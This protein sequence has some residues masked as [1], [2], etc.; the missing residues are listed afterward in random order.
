MLP[1][2]FDNSTFNDFF[3]WNFLPVET[4]KA[5][6]NFYTVKKSEDGYKYVFK[7]N[8]DSDSYHTT[9]SEKERI[10]EVSVVGKVRKGSYTMSHSNLET[11]EFEDDANLE[12]LTEKVTEEGLVI[13]VKRNAKKK[14]EVPEEDENPKWTVRDRLINKLKGEKTNDKELIRKLYAE[15]DDRDKE[16]AKMKADIEE[17]E[18]DRAYIGKLKEKCDFYQ[19]KY[20][21]IMDKFNSIKSMFD[22]EIEE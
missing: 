1:T 22:L 16:I 5:F 15:I 18:N 10:L 6:Q 13:E 21:A 4:K 11:I 7:F 2:I 19:K 20:E 12:T 3:N 8:K 14:R 17:R 9:L